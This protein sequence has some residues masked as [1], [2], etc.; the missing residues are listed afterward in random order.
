M[1]S[2]TSKIYKVEYLCTI[3]SDGDFCTSI[4][5][6]SSL[7]ESYEK[8]KIDGKKLFWG[9]KE[10]QVEIYDGKVLNSEH[11][12][13]HLKVINPNIENKSDFLSVLKVIRTILSRVN[14]NQ[15]PEILWDDISSEYAVK[16]YPIIH[17]LENLMRK[18]I[19]KFMITKVGLSW[20]K[21]NIP[22]EVSESIKNSSAS[23]KQNYIYNTDFIQLSN[24]LFNEYSMASSDKFIDEIKKAKKIGE[25]NLDELKKIVPLSNWTR[26]FNPIVQCTSEEL[27]KKWDILYQLRC[28]VAHNNFMNEDDFNNIIINSS[29]VKSIIQEA[30]DNLDKVTIKEEEKEEL[31]ENAAINLNKIYGEFVI[32]WKNIENIL[33][34]MSQ[35]NTSKNKVIS[36]IDNIRDLFKKGYITPREYKNFF[37]LR[38][39]RNLIIHDSN[40]ELNE[41]SLNVFLKD[42]ELWEN[43]LQNISGLVEQSSGVYEI[44]QAKDGQYR[45]VLKALNGEILLSSELYKDK[46]SAMNG[47]NAIRNSAQDECNFEIIEAKNGKSYFHLKA[48]NH[49]MIGISQFYN[50]LEE[51]DLAIELVKKYSQS[52]KISD[53]S[54][55]D[56]SSY[57][58]AE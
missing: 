55:D 53:L 28:K 26:Y 47:I 51:V 42:L 30:I 35:K 10:F 48:K 22:K 29:D 16:S 44:S 4:E 50:D 1:T 45:F 31:A 15:P 37:E 52:D 24:F 27:K 11:K 13:F 33:S 17:E 49:Q 8:L 39:I 56:D 20:T 46:V 38:N 14:N 6:F 7:L 23:K 21:E 12:Y 43:K 40:F 5:S 32:K 36:I 9:D 18:L 3:D 19:T 58:F 41:M 25:L 34:T 57:S 54:L 2:E